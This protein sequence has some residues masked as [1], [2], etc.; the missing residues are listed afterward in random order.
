M[1]EIGRRREKTRN[2][3]EA[4]FSIRRHMV[5]ER[6]EDGRLLKVQSLSARLQLLDRLLCLTRNC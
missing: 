3:K 2:M 1:V 4:E 5:D 6:S